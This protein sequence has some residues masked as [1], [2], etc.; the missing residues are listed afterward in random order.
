MSTE[1]LEDIR[2]GSQSRPNDNRR[3]VRY[4]IRDRIRQ[5]KLYY[6]GALKDT[7]NMGK[8]LRKVFKTVVNNILQKLPPL[9]ESGSEVSHFILKPRNVSE[10]T[11]LS[12]DVKKPLFKVTQNDIKNLINN[13]TF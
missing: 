7:Q 9:E 2:D 11:K 3:E 8:G 12:D 1:I 4:K 13:K 6:K 5:R 10:V